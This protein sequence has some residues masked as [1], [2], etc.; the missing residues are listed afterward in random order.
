MNTAASLFDVRQPS[1]RRYVEDYVSLHSVTEEALVQVI[2]SLVPS[3][4]KKKSAAKEMRGLFLNGNLELRGGVCLWRKSGPFP[5][6]RAMKR[7]RT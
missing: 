6:R 4:V 1:L 3:V 7:V 2:E 5:S